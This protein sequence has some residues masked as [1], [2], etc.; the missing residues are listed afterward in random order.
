[1]QS[2]F[3]PRLRLSAITLGLV[4]AAC[5]S[6]LALPPSNDPVPGAD[7][8]DAAVAPAPDAANGADGDADACPSAATDF[9]VKGGGACSFPTIT[10]A[11]DAARR[12][13]HYARTVHVPAGS[14]DAATERFPLDLRGGI[15]LVGA[16]VDATTITGVGSMSHDAEGGGVTGVF[17]ATL[18]AGDTEL[19]T[20]IRDIAVLSGL[21]NGGVT[22][23]VYGLLCDR[24]TAS[25]ADGPQPPPSLIVDRMS[26]GGP[27][28]GAFK[29]TTS[30]TP[31]SGCNARV[32]STT[33]RKGS[34]V[35]AVVGGCDGAPIAPPRVAVEV[36]DGVDAHKNTFDGLGKG[37]GM[38]AGLYI[39]DC[40]ASL[41]VRT[42]EFVRGEA[43][44]AFDQPGQDG[45]LSILG[46]HFVGQS[47]G[48]VQMRRL[49]RLGE[50]SNNVFEQ[51]RGAGIWVWSASAQIARARNNRFIGNS[52]G[53]RFDT[54]GKG[55]SFD[56]GTSDDPGLNELRCNSDAAKSGADVAVFAPGKLSF[57]G[58]LWDHAPPTAGSAFVDG[59]DLFAADGVTV[60]VGGAKPST[61][62][63]PASHV[64]GP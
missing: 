63:C 16:G 43:G 27:Y 50:V 28:G 37:D 34:W 24:G 45:T 48:G 38:G 39:G 18:V 54:G 31:R 11:V 60:D 19:T 6:I 51:C 25:D 13:A 32:T 26:F 10:A 29:A 57:F 8:G 53:V 41:T 42:N 46:N 55:G 59:L 49:N 12:R 2:L 40:V 7:G 30:T 22:N 1:M 61:S 47:M 36:G 44:I 5:E 33:F 4:C 14:Y 20:E 56:F 52:A 15:S 64:E 17:R 35:G 23:E 62:A 21:A 9:Y 3:R 58:N